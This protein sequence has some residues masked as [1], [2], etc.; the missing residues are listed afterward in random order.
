MRGRTDIVYRRTPFAKINS[1]KTENEKRDWEKKKYVDDKRCVTSRILSG[2]SYWSSFQVRASSRHFVVSMYRDKW[3]AV[4]RWF[5][6]A[7]ATWFLALSRS[8]L[9]RFGSSKIFDRAGR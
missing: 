5:D 6:T 1:I 4:T 3:P 2:D 8:I 7:P 9:T